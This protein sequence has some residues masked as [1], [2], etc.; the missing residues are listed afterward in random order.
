MMALLLL[1]SPLT[2]FEMKLE[3]QDDVRLSSS[4]PSLSRAGE[5]RCLSLLLV[6]SSLSQI[7]QSLAFLLKSGL[8]SNL[9]VLTRFAAAAA[10]LGP[11]ATAV[12]AALLFSSPSLLFYDSFLLNTALRCLSPSPFHPLHLF[13]FMLRLSLP[14]NHFTFPFLLKSVA[15]LPSPLVSAALSH[16]ASIRFGFAGDPLVQN[17]LIHAYGSSG[18]AGLEPAR[19]VFDETRKS[20]PVTFSSMIGGYV[21]SGRSNDAITLF[22]QMQLA[23]VRPDDVTITTVLSACVNLG[24]LEFAKWINSYIFRAQIPRSI[25]LSNAL[26][27]AL[28]KCGDIDA[29]MEVFNEMPER[30]IISWTSVIDGLAM[31]GRGDDA[32]RVFEGMKLARVQPDSVAFIGVLKACSHAGMV[33]A[34]RRYFESMTEEF[35]IEPR[36]EHYGCMV[37]L[38]S[39]AGIVEEAMGFLQSMPMKPNPVIWRTL[40]A[41]CRVHGR[42]ELGEKVTHQLI[43][44]DPLYDSN[45]VLLSNFYAL[46]RRW[47]KKWEIRTAMGQQGMRKAP[48]CSSLELNGE[49]YEFIAGGEKLS[50]NPEIREMVEEI[51]KKLK[52]VG[53]VAATKEVLL[54]LDEEDKEEALNWHSEKLAVAFALLKTSPG[55]IIRVVKNLRVCG[56]CHSAM[57]FISKVYE[58]EIVVRDRSR[59]HCFKD[60]VCSC[61]DFW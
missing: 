40:I 51:A 24:A 47:K 17:T 50:M 33:T 6:S 55:T 37:D 5:Q 48:G 16:A 18:D 2:P 19:K 7:L 3:S 60:G 43:K 32:V 34:G 45:Y 8:Q 52:S 10:P 11:A 25:S 28:A 22:R 39:R 54:D 56:D 57:K 42:L 31:H 36:I 21:R 38:F 13:S 46:K 59:F 61:K 29:A 12:A 30:N 1:T 23:C 9:L 44:E 49:I 26:I 20:N 4:S 14:P 15:A 35:G 53:Y 58:R 27:D 41:A